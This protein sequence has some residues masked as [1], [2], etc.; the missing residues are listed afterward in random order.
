MPL[1]QT[2]SVEIFYEEFG[3]LDAPVILLVMGLGMQMIGWP[4][5]FCQSLADRGF[6]VVRFDNRDTGL[7]TKISGRKV[8]VTSALMRNFMGMKIDVPYT[9]DDMAGDAVGLMNAL[10]IDKAHIVGASMGGMIAQIVAAKHAERIKSLTSIMSSSGNPRLP[11]GKPAATGTLMARRPARSDYEASIQ[12][13][14]DIHRIIGSPG[15]PAS[16]D[17]LRANIERAHDRSYYPAGLIRQFTAVLASGSRVDLLKTIKS[18]TLV[19]H[20]AD[21]PLVPVE[22]GEDTARHIPGAALKVIPGWGHDFPAELILV[23]VQLI[24]NH[25]KDAEALAVAR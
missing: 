22:A 4:D 14:M 15:Y 9:L 17:V 23:F 5:R 12:F 8:D 18:P 24:A 21:D 1:I 6:C 2:N 10:G 3:D 11:A 7:S 13:E 16:D 19:L 25:C 20:G